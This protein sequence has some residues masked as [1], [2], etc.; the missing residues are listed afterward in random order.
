VRYINQ[1][2]VSF[3]TFDGR[4]I[5]VRELREIPTYPKLKTIPVYSGSFVDEIASRRDIYGADAE[6]ESYKII[7]HNKIKF[8]E[9]NFNLY[10]FKILEIPSLL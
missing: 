8:V 7:E 4:K 3:I 10:R 9:S 6:G 2:T 5:P 1:N